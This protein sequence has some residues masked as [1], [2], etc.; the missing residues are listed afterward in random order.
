MLNQ[1]RIDAELAP[2]KGKANRIR[3]ISQLDLG[4]RPSPKPRFFEDSFFGKENPRS[5]QKT[6]GNH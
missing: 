3:V 5:S 1:C 4:D 6:A 2:E